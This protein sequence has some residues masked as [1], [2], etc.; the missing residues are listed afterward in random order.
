[1]LAGY[2]DMSTA[3]TVFQPRPD[4]FKRV[5]MCVAPNPF[6][7]AVVYGFVVVTGLTQNF[8][9]VKLV[10]ANARAFIYVLFNDRNQSCTASIR[11]DMGHEI[12]VPF[13]HSEN[14][15]FLGVFTWS[16]H[17]VVFTA[18]IGFV[19]LDVTRQPIVTVRIGHV[20]AN[21]MAHSPSTLVGDAQL[22][23]QFL[24][25]DSMPGC[26]EQVHGVEPLLEGRPGSLK[27]SSRHWVDV[28]AAPRTLKRWLFGDPAELAV[29]RT[30]RAIK[31]KAES[32]AH[33]VIQAG[34]IIWE[35]LEK[36]CN[37]ELL[38]HISHLPP[39]WGNYGLFAY[40]CQ[41]DNRQ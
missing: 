11:D 28:M 17:N 25:G 5:R 39:M 4:T 3:N 20:L 19:D 32:Y 30:L 6:H 10:S 16:A 13:D 36:V 37:R 38:S 29:F 26:G 2:V 18:N 7:S 15:G 41:G 33:Q 1:M 14:G 31:L 27:W 8:V 35:A 9:G 24:S 22:P 40:I 23:L 34:I 21:F 12:T